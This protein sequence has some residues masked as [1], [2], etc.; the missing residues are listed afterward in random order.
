MS[1]SEQDSKLPD[2]IKCDHF[3]NQLND[4]QL[5]EEARVPCACPLGF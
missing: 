2:S 1:S 5:V 3:C 4:R